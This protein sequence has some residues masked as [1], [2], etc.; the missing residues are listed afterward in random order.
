M[1]VSILYWTLRT[2]DKSLVIP[3]WAQLPLLADLSFHAIPSILLTVDLLLFSPPW[4]VSMTQA[5]ALSTVLAFLYWP[6]VETCA[7]HN[8]Y[9]PYPIF[10]MV[11]TKGR[12]GLFTMSALV[13]TGSTVMLKALYEKVNG[14]EEVS[15]NSRRGHNTPMDESSLPEAASGMARQANYLA[16]GMKD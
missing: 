8:G 3:D 16:N 6:W 9:Y 4:T 13:M 1:L 15:G 12:V 2:V 10:D 5:F 14:K 11:G 7:Q